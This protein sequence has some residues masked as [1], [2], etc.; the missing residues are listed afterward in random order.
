MADHQKPHFHAVCV[1][2]LCGAKLCPVKY[3]DNIKLLLNYFQKSYKTTNIKVTD[4]HCG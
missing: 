3:N 1:T 2:I 4:V